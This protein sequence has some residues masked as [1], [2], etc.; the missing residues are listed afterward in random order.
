MSLTMQVDW[1][2]LEVGSG[3]PVKFP[4]VLGFDVAGVVAKVGRH[5]G[6]NRISV[7]DRVW[8]DL[9]QVWPLRGGQLGAVCVQ[10]I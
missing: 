2:L 10:L 4:H 8:A 1:K 3:L 7:G 6:E 9:G 5:V